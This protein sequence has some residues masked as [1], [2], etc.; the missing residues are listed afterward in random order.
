MYLNPNQSN[1][2]RYSLVTCTDPQFLSKLQR[3]KVGVKI[4]RRIWMHLN[5]CFSNKI[6]KFIDNWKKFVLV[7]CTSAPSSGSYCWLLSPIEI[8]TLIADI[9]MLAILWWLWLRITSSSALTTAHLVCLATKLTSCWVVFLELPD[10]H[11][12]LTN[13]YW[14]T[15]DQRQNG[16]TLAL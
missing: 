13:P 16:P 11:L 7:S 10:I 1:L 14:D 15:T 9:Q 4:L 2:V 8:C 6:P 12:T 5:E 3:T